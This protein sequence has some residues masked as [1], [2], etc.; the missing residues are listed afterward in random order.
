METV[1]TEARKLKKLRNK[2]PVNWL[3]RKGFGGNFSASPKFVT[4]GHVLLLNSAVIENTKIEQD[5]VSKLVT[6][7]DIVTTWQMKTRVPSR[8]AYFIGCGVWSDGG[9]V[10][11]LHDNKEY[12]YVDPYKLSFALQAVAADAMEVAKHQPDKNPIILYREA[13]PVGL[14]MPLRIIDGGR[15]SLPDRYDLEAA[16][17]VPI[18]FALSREK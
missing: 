14:L 5:E 1:Q 16:I 6:E 7:G 8:L 4:D 18:R 2:L 15:S 11:V 12:V 9:A 3:G 10:A 13:N 17:P